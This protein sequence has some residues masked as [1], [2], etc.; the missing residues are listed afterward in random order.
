MGKGLARRELRARAGLG[1]LLAPGSSRAL[2]DTHRDGFRGGKPNSLSNALP[3]GQRGFLPL[4]LGPAEPLRGH[5]RTAAPCAA[6]SSHPSSSSAAS[7]SVLHP[8]SLSHSCSM[9]YLIWSVRRAPCLLRPFVPMARPDSTLGEPARGG[10]TPVLTARELRAHSTALPGKG[11]QHAALGGSRR[12]EI[13]AFTRRHPVTAT[14]VPQASC[15][16][17]AP[18]TFSRRADK[19]V[20]GISPGPS[21]FVLIL[22]TAQLFA[23][24]ASHATAPPGKAQGCK[25]SA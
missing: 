25:L 15:N 23:S 6:R 21:I 1:L 5:V 19:K 13:Q 4:P 8:P 14:A 20:A 16:R 18:G 7:S 10:E 24:S 12:H 17:S 9:L 11:A 3:R 2:G 22:K